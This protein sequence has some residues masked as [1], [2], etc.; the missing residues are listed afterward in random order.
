MKRYRA[1]ADRRERDS[2]SAH[3]RRKRAAHFLALLAEIPRPVRIL[4]VGGEEAFWDVI[5]TEPGLDILLVNIEPQT[6]R[7]TNVRFALADARNLAEFGDGSF[8]LVVSNSVIEHVDDPAA[9][10]REIQRVG[11]HFYVQTPN[12]WF[13]IEPH[14]LVPFFQFLPR[15]ARAWLLTRFDLGWLTR[16]PDR[17]HAR[18]VV[19]SINLLGARELRALFPRARLWRERFFGLTKSLVVF[20]GWN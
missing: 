10:A 16:S 14:F 6:P 19:A 2:L 7:G 17:E 3:F 15:A 12:K 11:R 18:A 4:D 9:M 8:D 13:P 5:G 20:G 1:L